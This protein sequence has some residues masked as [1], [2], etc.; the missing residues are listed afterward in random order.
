MNFDCTDRTIGVRINSLENVNMSNWEITHTLDSLNSSNNKLN[1]LEEISIYLNN[2]GKQE[3][4]FILDQS[5][6]IKTNYKEYFK[7]GSRL[8]IND[9]ADLKKMIFMGNIVPFYFNDKLCKLQFIMDT[10]RKLNLELNRMVRNKL[11]NGILEMSVNNLC[12]S[13][14][15]KSIENLY[16]KSKEVI[17]SI[18]TNSKIYD[19]EKYQE[20]IKRLDKIYSSQ[21][22]SYDEYMIKSRDCVNSSFKDIFK[23]RSRPIVGIYHEETNQFEIVNYYQMYMKGELSKKDLRLNMIT[24]NSPVMILVAAVGL[25]ASTMI[26]LAIR[27]HN[28]SDENEYDVEELNIPETEYDLVTTLLKTQNSDLHELGSEVLTKT[29]EVT[30]KSRVVVSIEEYRDNK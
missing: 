16:I 25:M 28:V 26:Y 9:E 7:N 14:I 21:Q 10:Y 30:D 4:I 6:N 22:N 2:G 18:C 27:E 17:D 15:E 19:Q 13:E 8:S 11:P 24:K 29:K 1:I 3:N 5:F 12:D 20:F 23:T